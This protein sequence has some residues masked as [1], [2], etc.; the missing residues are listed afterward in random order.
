MQ[1]V[2]YTCE[3]SSIDVSTFIVGQKGAG[4]SPAP[5]RR[6]EDVESGTRREH[7][8]SVFVSGA[9]NEILSRIDLRRFA[10]LMHLVVT[11]SFVSCC[12]FLL[13]VFSGISV[14]KF[15]VEEGIDALTSSDVMQL[16]ILFVEEVRKKGQKICHRKFLSG[17]L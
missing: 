3:V 10:R 4:V 16:V 7:G 12:D 9:R 8:F 14:E 5:A 1:N 13:F 2:S 6:L 17:S 11:V 15:L